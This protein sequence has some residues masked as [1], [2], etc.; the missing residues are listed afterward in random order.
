M[1]ARDAAAQVLREAGK[2]LP[3]G[4]VADLVLSR[5]LWTTTGR[6]PAKTIEARICMDIRTNGD[7]S[8]FVRVA[9]RVFGLRELGHQPMHE[10]PARKPEATRKPRSM[11]A[12]TCS[13]TDAAERVL[14][15]FGK[16]KP[17]HYREITVKAL[18]EGW[19][20]T[21]GKTPE[22]SMYAGIVT[23]IDRSK[24]RG[25]QPRFAKHGRGFIGLTRWMGHGLAFEIEQENRRV[26]RALHKELCRTEPAQFEHL[27][28]ALLTKL[29]FDVQ[30]TQPSG[31]GGIDVRG[32]LV[33]GDVIKTRMALQVKRWKS[34]VQKPVVQQVRGS[35]GAHEQ[36][37]IITTS[38]FS[39][40]A[41]EEALRSD[42]QPVALMNG[43][44]L[45]NLMIEKDVGITRETFD[46]IGLAEDESE[47]IAE[48]E[49]IE[50]SPST[51]EA[52]DEHTPKVV[53][54]EQFH[55]DRVD[56]SVRQVYAYIKRRVEEIDPSFMM[57][58]KKGYISLR[59]RRN[60][61]FLRFTKKKARIIIMLPEDQ[62]QAAVHHHQVTLPADSVKAFYNGPC[63]TV[64]IVN[65]E[66]IEEVIDLLKTVMEKERK[67]SEDRV[68]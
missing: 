39:K 33:V 23:E 16:K 52:G 19:L 63:A 67:R 30:V 36:G 28:G 65:L 35:L 50:P 21:R 56:D 9:P 5:R 45:V 24:K 48:F 4:E 64:T 2:P 29:G 68:K 49:T 57:N 54:S 14:G 61:A 26:R 7:E 31:D 58:P 51:P 47:E 62:I 25:E 43:D 15:Q 40:G 22:A 20:D 13:F 44:Q 17:M 38:D 46:I 8:L 27:I 1:T 60:V 37:L 18:R 34:N 3:F 12:K 10:K 6:T 53:Y 55:L 66:H 32:T 59:R 41:Q 11:K 42:A